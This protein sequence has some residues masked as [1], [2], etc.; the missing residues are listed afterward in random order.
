VVMALIILLG[1][2]PKPINDLAASA[3]TTLVHTL[4]PGI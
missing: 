1:L 2:F 4:K 3:A